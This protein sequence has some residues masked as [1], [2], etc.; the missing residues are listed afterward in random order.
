[1][2][3]E[4]TESVL[5]LRL[6]HDAVLGADDTRHQLTEK[7]GWSLLSANLYLGDSYFESYFCGLTQSLQCIYRDIALK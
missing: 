4:Y 6:C 2:V 3:R 1:M 7:Y 5:L